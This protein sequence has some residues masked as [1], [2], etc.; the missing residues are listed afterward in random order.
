MIRRAAMAVVALLALGSATSPATTYLVRPDG[1]GDFATI[2]EAVEAAASG[3]SVVLADG[4]YMLSRTIDY[5]GKD[6]VLCSASGDPTTCTIV[7]H[8]GGE[9]V[10]IT[11]VPTDA[12]I[13]RGVTIQGGATAVVTG[14][15]SPVIR[16]CVFRDNQTTSGAGIYCGTGSPLIVNCLF[17]GNVAMGPFGS[18]IPGWGGGICVV[19]GSPRIVDCTFTG[20]LAGGVGGAVYAS[21]GSTTLVNCRITGGGIDGVYCTG[22]TL[23][24]SDCIITGNLGCGVSCHECTCTIIGSTIASNDNHHPGGGLRVGGGGAVH[25]ERCV[26]WGNCST[27]GAAEVFVDVGCVAEFACCIVDSAG[28]EGDGSITGLGPNSY[29][30]PLFCDPV[31]CSMEP[32]DSGD[33]SVSEASPCTPENSACGALIGALPAA[34]PGQPAAEQTTWGA[35]KAMFR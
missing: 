16:D 2:P 23:D 28:V 10:V 34:C 24:I 15:S 6:I 12:A 29:E 7:P 11:H 20:N 25:A 1:T 22:G 8:S 32:T 18:G 27:V 14:A 3:D 26:I 17:E 5:D 21:G 33:Y 13:L 19:E 31:P 30:D 4:V 35:I 9:G